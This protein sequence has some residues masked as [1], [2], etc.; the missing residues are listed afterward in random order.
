[1]EKYCFT[2]ITVYDRAFPLGDV[3]RPSSTFGIFL[4]YQDETPIT[5]R[6]FLSSG[7]K[8]AL[9]WVFWDLNGIPTLSLTDPFRTIRPVRRRFPPHEVGCKIG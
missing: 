9:E 6:S 7:A 3:F 4:L 1:M 5:T 2:A 8:D